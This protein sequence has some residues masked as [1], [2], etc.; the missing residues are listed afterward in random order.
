MSEILWFLK[1]MLGKFIILILW[2]IFN[3]IFKLTSHLI[4]GN[5]STPNL[6]QVW[7]HTSGKFIEKLTRRNGNITLYSPLLFHPHILL[8]REI[9][10]K[11]SS[12]IRM[13]H[14]THDWRNIFTPLLSCL[15]DAHAGGSQKCA[16][17]SRETPHS[18]SFYWN[19]FSS[20]VKFLRRIDI[21]YVQQ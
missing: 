18:T 17:I 9:N 5:I 1:L 15:A 4:S 7:S 10:N 16:G 2:P 13:D 12:G 19:V 14:P 8:C 11:T 21:L 20:S 6:S 3:L